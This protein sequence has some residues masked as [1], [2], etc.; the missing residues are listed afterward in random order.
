MIVRTRF[1]STVFDTCRPFVWPNENR[2]SLLVTTR[3]VVHIIQFHRA[4]RTESA[5]VVNEMPHVRSQRTFTGHRLSRDKLLSSTTFKVKCPTE[6]RGELC[7]HVT[8]W[9]RQRAQL[10]WMLLFTLQAIVCR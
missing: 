5:D 10:I 9:F 3:L 4:T 6:R 7:V 8:A 1:V 2:V